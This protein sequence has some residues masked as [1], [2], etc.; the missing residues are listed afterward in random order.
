MIDV[1][2]Y[3]AAVGA[4]KRYTDEHSSS[5]DAVKYTEQSLTTAQQAQARENIGAAAVSDIPSVIDYSTT[6]QDTGIKW[7]DG[8]NVYQKTYVFDP[9]VAGGYNSYIDLVD[10]S[11]L[12]IDTLIYMSGIEHDMT[13]DNIATIE[14]HTSNNE[15]LF[16]TADKSTVKYMSPLAMEFLTLRYTRAIIIIK[17]PESVTV[18]AGKKIELSIVAEGNNLSYLW[19]YKYNMGDSWANFSSTPSSLTPNFSKTMREDLDG[20]FMHCRVTDINGRVVYSDVVTVTL[21]PSDGQK[22]IPDDEKQG[23][24]IDDESKTLKN[25]NGTFTWVDDM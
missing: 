14:T 3:G 11:G 19:Q 17:Q 23:E 10:V 24:P 21:A 15:H 20:L 18:A 7:V 9:P 4:A 22:Y 13:Y 8:K 6:E 25:I 12:S 1:E 2:T 16:L 5:D